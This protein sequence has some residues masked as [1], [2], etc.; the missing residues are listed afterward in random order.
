[1][2]LFSPLLSQ[3]LSTITLESLSL[4]WQYLTWLANQPWAV[5]KLSSIEQQ[6]LIVLGIISAILFLFLPRISLGRSRWLKGVLAMIVLMVVIPIKSA[7]VHSSP[8]I[9]SKNKAVINWQLVVF[10]VGQGLSVLIQHNDKAILYDT[11]AAYPSGF[12]MA[13]SVILPYLQHQG[14]SALDK[15]IISHSDNDHAGGLSQLQKTVPIKELIMNDN[16]ASKASFCQQGKS[17]NWQGLTIEMLWPK[18]LQGKENDDSCVLLVSSSKH[19]VLLTGDISKQTEYALIGE[20]PQLEVD[21]L[22][23]PHH[24]SKTSSSTEFIKHTS[25]QTAIVS[26]GFLNRWHMPVREV[27]NRYKQDNLKLINTAEVGQVIINFSN[28]G[29]NQGIKVQNYHDDL[30][31]F[32]FAK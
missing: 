20:Y 29:V 10:D 11:G 28:Q 26:A 22:V 9:E 19:K 27:V 15:V 1:M 2:M 24:G 21:V 13:E 4:L 8:S 30:W 17:F 5:V 6:L 14:I 18:T 32:W 25:P 7:F 31:P 16:K 23:V 3:A 12:N